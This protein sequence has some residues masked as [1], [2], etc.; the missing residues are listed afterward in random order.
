MWKN[1]VELCPG[2]NGSVYWEVALPGDLA[3]KLP[4]KNISVVRYSN[5]MFNGTKYLDDSSTN[6]DGNKKRWTAHYDSYQEDGHGIVTMT[7]S[8]TNFTWELDIFRAHLRLDIEGQTF[9]TGNLVLFQKKT[10]SLCNQDD[11][12]PSEGSI[13][14]PGPTSGPGPHSTQEP[15]PNEKAKTCVHVIV[16]NHESIIHIWASTVVIVIFLKWST[17]LSWLKTIKDRLTSWCYTLRQ[18]SGRSNLSGTVLK[19][20]DI[21]SHVTPSYAGMTE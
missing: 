18:F 7:I 19:D 15:T 4:P 16:N 6:Y 1:P 20:E 21:A 9:V 3:N 8:V 13:P 10:S 11:T 14:S 12:S 5:R 2:E 17:I